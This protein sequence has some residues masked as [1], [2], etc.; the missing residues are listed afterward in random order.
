MGVPQG[1]ILG[2]L[3][4]IIY[5]NDIATITD[6]ANIYLFVD[7]TA[8]MFK[9]SN[10][11]TLQE[12]ANTIMILLAEWFTANR[13]SLNVSKTYYQIYSGHCQDNI[14]I[15]IGNAMIVR[16]SCIKYLGVY[17]DEDLKWKN[18]I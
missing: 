3:L 7:D 6:L 17:I 18:H 10:I 1:S 9:S 11:V 5:I 16:K 12:K 14:N 8:V 4:F 13:L 15:S 2:P